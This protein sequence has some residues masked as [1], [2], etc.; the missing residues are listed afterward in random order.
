MKTQSHWI[1]FHKP[2]EP[3]FRSVSR[4]HISLTWLHCTPCVV[5][6]SSELTVLCDSFINT[7]LD[8]FICR[9]KVVVDAKHASSSS[10][11]PS[12]RVIQVKQGNSLTLDCAF[13]VS[14]KFDELVN[15]PVKWFWQERPI[16]N[17]SRGILS[18]QVF[19][20]HESETS[21]NDSFT[22]RKVSLINDIHSRRE[23]QFASRRVH[24]MPIA[25]RLWISSSILCTFSV[26][27]PKS[28][29]LK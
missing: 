13:Y 18:N 6:W 25:W 12:C 4:I 22:E 3:V 21:F 16:G 5:Q 1:L 24:C 19:L 8:S 11:C 17:N 27:R 28:L 7:D 9:P 14:E 2:N 23:T 15:L 26:C 20:I 10:S 29:G